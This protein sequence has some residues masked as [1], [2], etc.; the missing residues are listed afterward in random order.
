M[1]S[2]YKGRN[3]ISILIS[4]LF[5]QVITG[6]SLTSLGA[7]KQMNRNVYS[8]HKNEKNPVIFMKIDRNLEHWVKKNKQE[9]ESAGSHFL[10]YMEH[11]NNIVLK[12]RGNIERRCIYGRH[13][14]I[15]KP[16]IENNNEYYAKCTV[17]KSR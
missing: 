13:F 15:I 17:E 1:K 9:T 4:A 2:E 11:E 14:G 6:I 7:S 8:S 3:D 12:D 16:K 5:K 10:S